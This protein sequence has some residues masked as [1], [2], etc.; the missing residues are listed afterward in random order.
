ME[1][2]IQI[3]ENNLIEIAKRMRSLAQNGIVYSQNPYDTERY[4][5]LIILSDT[6]ASLLTGATI[7][8]IETCYAPAKDYVTPKV[9]VRAVVFN[10]QGKLLMA[11][12]LS[13]GCWTPPGGWADVGYTPTEVAVKETKE[14]TGLDVEPVRLLAVL[15]KRQHP[16]PAEPY[17]IYKIFILCRQTGGV[18]T[19]AHDITGCAFFGKN[20]LPRLSMNRITPDQL[21][22][23]FR[24]RDNPEM[25]AIID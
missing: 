3:V 23:I 19:T 14:E 18:L 8:Q 15:D 13:D 4:E 12:E 21:E 11:Q 1:D 22:M 17:Y 10:E 24:F 25:Q 9:D 20:E 2:E 5:E 16:H 6:M 7:R